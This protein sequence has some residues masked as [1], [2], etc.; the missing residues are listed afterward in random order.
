MT[1]NNPPHPGETLREDVLPALGL[2]ITEAATQLNVTRAAL[3]R[4]LNGRA[5][6]SPEMA[7]RLEGW[8]GVENG[9]RADLWLA[10]QAT[11]DLWKARQTG[12]PQVRRAVISPT[13]LTI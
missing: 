6:I 11:Y 7:L 10:Q 4:V 1:R 13:V 9:G 8:L 2:T 3:S 5:A 12:A